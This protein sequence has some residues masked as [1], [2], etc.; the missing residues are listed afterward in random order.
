[1]QLTRERPGGAGKEQSRREM[2]DDRTVTAN[3][4]EIGPTLPRKGSALIAIPPLDLRG[5][6]DLTSVPQHHQF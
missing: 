5:R 4:H 3:D 6:R 2:R 1:M